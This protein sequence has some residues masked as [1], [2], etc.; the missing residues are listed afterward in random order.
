MTEKYY[1]AYFHWFINDVEISDGVFNSLTQG[2]I[3]NRKFMEA[4]NKGADAV[5]EHY[6]EW[7]K[8]FDALYGDEPDEDHKIYN[9]FICQKQNEILKKVPDDLFEL[10]TDPEFGECSICGRLKH[11][12]NNDVKVQVMFKVIE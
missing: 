4:H 9:R 8:E 6:E 2:K 12:K 7:N 11:I 3:L 10:F 5:N 1:R